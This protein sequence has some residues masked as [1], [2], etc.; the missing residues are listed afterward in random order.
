[1]CESSPITDA[2]SAQQY[3]T[4]ECNIIVGDLYIQNI[5]PDLTRNM[6]AEYLKGIKVIRGRLHI[7]NTLDSQ[8]N[9]FDNLHTVDSIHILNG[10]RVLDARFPSVTTFRSNATVDG[11]ERLCPARYPK[12]VNTDEQL[13]PL[14][15]I[16]FYL[17]VAGNGVPNLN[18][19][20]LSKLMERV[21]KNVTNNQV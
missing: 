15:Q 1:L 11:C 21:I 16:E 4:K 19:T 20:M 14:R 18:L 7:I 9:Y 8:V 17:Y 6:I 3:Q 12:P 10:P 2:A 5:P 13:C